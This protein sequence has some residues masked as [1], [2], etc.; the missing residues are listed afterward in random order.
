MAERK[1]TQFLFCSSI[2]RQ[3][4]T[5]TM[6]RCRGKNNLLVSVQP[7]T[8]IF[9]KNINTNWAWQDSLL[10]GFRLEMRTNVSHKVCVSL[11]ELTTAPMLYSTCGRYAWFTCLSAPLL[12]L[13]AITYAQC[14][15]VDRPVVRTVTE[16]VHR[17]EPS[18][19]LYSFCLYFW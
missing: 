1:A 9:T 7:D 18:V 15:R 13:D 12:A 6:V 11:Y 8:R 14:V 19:F 4:H 5:G 17:L 3:P 16:N 2:S 10:S